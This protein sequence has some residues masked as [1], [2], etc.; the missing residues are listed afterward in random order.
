MSYHGATNLIRRAI[1]KEIRQ[2]TKKKIEKDG[3]V[4]DFSFMLMNV[5]RRHF[6]R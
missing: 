5:K 4:D 3:I 2:E 6:I 1:S